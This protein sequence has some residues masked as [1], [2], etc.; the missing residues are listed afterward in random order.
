MT[1]QEAN[2]YVL[3]RLRRIYPDGEAAEIT[4]RVMENLTGSKKAE[5]M[6][7]KNAAITSEEEKKL[8]QFTER[9]M[10]HE[11]VQY[12]LNEAW[13]YNHKFY[14]DK[15]VLIPR[16]ETEEL[17]DWVLKEIR[18]LPA[19][20]A[21]QKSNNFKILDIGTGS[22][23]IAIALKKNLPKEF[24]VLACD[25]N[26]QVLTVARKNAAEAGV[27]I[28]FTKLDFLNIT[29]RT[30]LPLV[31]IIVSNPPYVPL[32]D[33]DTM[34]ANVINHEP[35]AALFVP[36]NDPL[37]FYNAIAGFANEKLNDSGAIFVEL[38]EDMNNQAA[39]LFHL[40]GYP[41]TEL[42]KDMQGKVRML[43]AA[44]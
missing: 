34:K 9:L 36:D 38:H 12:I 22:G 7:Y 18:S 44:R 6:I 32:K 39:G 42:R 29:Q 25:N 10:R 16:P 41:A 11:P 35:H 43:K 23:C 26:E 15:N 31:D 1:I 20:Q 33:K 28:E 2:Y 17:V 8:I 37:I 13:F 30:R 40:K 24:E 21:G 3:N 14:V 19:A 27:E 4:D 5:R